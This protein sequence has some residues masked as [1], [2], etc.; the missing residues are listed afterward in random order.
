MFQRIKEYF[1][2][3]KNKRMLRQELTSMAAAVLAAAKELAEQAE[4]KKEP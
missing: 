1:D 2:Y 3:K 4:E